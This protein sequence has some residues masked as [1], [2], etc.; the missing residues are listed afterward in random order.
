MEVRYIARLYNDF[1]TKF[2]LPRQ[3]GMA[4]HLLSRI[5]MEKPYRVAEAFRGIEGYER[6]WLVWEFHEAKKEGEWSPTV[7]PPRLGGNERVG[8]FATRSP[9]RPNAIGLSC[10]KLEKFYID[11][12]EGPVLIVSGADLQNGTPI[13]DIKPY[14]PYADSYPKA[15]AGFTDT[16]EK[17]TLAVRYAVSLPSDMTAEQRAA[18]DEA[19]K[20]DPRPAY[21]SD[22]DRVY[23]M[24][25]GK[26]DVRF[27]VVGDELIVREVVGS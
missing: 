16:T 18:L 5:V 9:Y 7:R 8:V 15:A 13:L 10:V 20:N 17:K 24:S 11:E 23:G 3:S 19:L 27:G 14:L 6:L 4:D 25:Y 21:Q 1:N 26:W 12:K 22:P 2:G